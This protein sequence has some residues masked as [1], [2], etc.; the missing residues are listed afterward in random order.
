MLIKIL[1]KTLRSMPER[2]TDGSAG[3][4]LRAAIGKKLTVDPGDA[5]RVR[6]GIAIHIENKNVTGL[7]FPR[8]GLGHDYG[9]VLGNC[10]GVIDSDYQ[11]EI[12]VS[13]WNRS[14]FS[15][16]INPYDRIA[17]LVFV[18]IYIPEFEIVETFNPTER[19]DRGFGHTGK[20]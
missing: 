2:K 7:I 16:D 15:Y 12:L 9:I 13:L 11:G 6:T 3:F 10:T 17:Q 8:S 14:D 1:D 5:V 19:G 4:D 18:N 20:N